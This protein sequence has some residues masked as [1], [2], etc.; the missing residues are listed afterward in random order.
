VGLALFKPGQV[1]PSFC[2]FL[3]LITSEAVETHHDEHAVS[4]T[5]CPR[6]VALTGLI[7]NSNHGNFSCLLLIDGDFALDRGRAQRHLTRRDTQ[8]KQRDSGTRQ[9]GATRLKPRDMESSVWGLAGRSPGRR[10]G[11][12]R[13]R[14]DV[15]RLRRW[16]C[17]DRTSGRGASNLTRMLIP[18]FKGSLVRPSTRSISLRTTDI[19]SGTRRLVDSASRPAAPG[20]D[21]T[22]PH[23]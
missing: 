6:S 20:S 12:A 3:L 5:T 2:S 7:P 18:P 21:P 13:A 9:S 1:F 23:Y 16:L 11:T 4:F 15:T 8:D 19:A 14:R 17:R 22:S 10:G